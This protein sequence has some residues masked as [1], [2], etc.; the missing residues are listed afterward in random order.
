MIKICF[1]KDQN[2]ITVDGH[3]LYGEKG[4]DIVCAAVSIL[5]YTLAENLN[6]ISTANAVFEEGHSAIVCGKSCCAVKN[7]AQIDTA[8]DV[9]CKGYKLLMENYPEHVSFETI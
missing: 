1:Y 3:A 2:K 6:G 5:T 4:K 7:A 8:F 9:I